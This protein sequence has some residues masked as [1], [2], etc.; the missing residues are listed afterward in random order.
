[1]KKENRGGARAGAGRPAKPSKEYSEEFKA[2]F[3]DAL[4]K[5]AKETGKT[6]YEI[7]IDMYYDR[8]TQAVAKLGVLKILTEVF[9]IKESKRTIEEVFT[10]RVYLPKQTEKPAEA[11]ERERKSLA[12][13]TQ[14]KGSC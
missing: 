7:A 8:R 6:I 12:E 9:V 1:M 13:L 10:P 14:V 5:K 3:V 4:A 11:I 2:G